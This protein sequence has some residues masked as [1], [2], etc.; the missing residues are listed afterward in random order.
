MTPKRPAC[1]RCG[2]RK[3]DDGRCPCHQ[4]DGIKKSIALARSI[5]ARWGGKESNLLASDAFRHERGWLADSYAILR[6]FGEAP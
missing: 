6:L 2:F 4:Y 5:V 3:D 1:D